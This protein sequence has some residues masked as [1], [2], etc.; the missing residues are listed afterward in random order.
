MN[1]P[2][3]PGLTAR[4]H[5]PLETRIPDHGA[6]IEVAPGVRWLRMRLPFQLDHINLWL[7]R[8][9]LKTDDGPVP[10]W[11]V[12]DCGVHDDH[13]RDQWEQVFAHE[14]DGL[15]ILRVIATHMHPDHLG[16]A[17]WLCERWTQPGR[18]CR[19]WI[20]APDH[21]LACLNSQRQSSG[22]SARVA[23]FVTSHGLQDP[24]VL[25]HI[26]HRNLYPSLVPSVPWAFH[27]LMDGMRLQIG[28]HEWVCISGHGHAP[29]HMALYCQS[30]GVLISGD[31]VLPRISSVVGVFENEPEGDP[32]ALFLQSL[33]KFEPL[34]PNTLVL[35]SHGTPFVGLHAR[36]EQLQQHHLDRLADTESACRQTSRSAHDILPLLFRRPLDAMQTELAMAEALAHLHFLWHAGRLR[37]RLDADGIFRFGH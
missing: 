27:R 21:H 3:P 4:L 8:D 25:D 14:L 13:T 7:L 16:L 22:H 33:R 26:R 23:E 31:M 30:L 28:G 37:R 24:A 35:P 2:I 36:L 11:T 5:H 6:S 12:V 29:E 1:A 17:D 32:L 18:A 19:L 15:P 34:A 20:S 10:G 9:E